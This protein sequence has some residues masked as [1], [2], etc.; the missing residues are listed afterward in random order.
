MNA[1]T[2]EILLHPVRLRVVLAFGPEELT[3]T[4]LG[5]RLPD[6]APATLYRQV[7]VLTDAGLLEVVDERRVR[8]GVER[9]YSLVPA[10]IQVSPDDLASMSS[11]DHLRGFLAFIGSLVGSLAT[12]LE[13]DGS[14]PSG[15]GF[16]YRQA[17]VWATPS[18]RTRMAKEMRAVMAP[19]LAME[20]TPARDRLLLNAILIPDV[21]PRASAKPA[22]PSDRRVESGRSRD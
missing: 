13:A 17:A 8:G 10:A 15:D 19:Y 11:D 5:D 18:E 7:A 14:D 4:D 1:K 16:S 22:R 20:P 2:S 3:T 12:Y 21:T 6:I 9:T